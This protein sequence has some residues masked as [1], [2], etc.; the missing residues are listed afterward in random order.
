MIVDIY[1]WYVINET[2]VKQH[3]LIKI[4]FLSVVDSH[5][6]GTTGF[7]LPFHCWYREIYVIPLASLGEE[8]WFNSI[9]SKKY[10]FRWKRDLVKEEEKCFFFREQQKYISNSRA[11]TTMMR[12]HASVRRW[13][14]T[15]TTIF[16]SPINDDH[17]SSY[18]R[19][20]IDIISTINLWEMKSILNPH[21]ETESNKK[22]A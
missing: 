18:G 19:D 22:S 9:N 5:K 10:S 2:K 11:T 14:M 12:S 6:L 21:A 3:N 7:S 8:S 15:T 20:F 16:F 4:H 1:D 13:K 17:N